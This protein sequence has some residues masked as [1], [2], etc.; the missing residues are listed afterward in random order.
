MTS[1]KRSF[2]FSVV[3]S[4]LIG[5]KNSLSLRMS[6]TYGKLATRWLSFSVVTIMAVGYS[7]A[8]FLSELMSPDVNS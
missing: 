8:S 5:A 3:N 1:M 4:A 6:G 2:S 7:S